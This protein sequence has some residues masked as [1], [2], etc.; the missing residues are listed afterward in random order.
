MSENHSE[1][2]KQKTPM[3]TEIREKE[4]EPLPTNSPFQGPLGSIVQ[5]FAIFVAISI[6][7]GRIYSLT[8]YEVLGIPTSE[9]RL[10]LTD[11]AVISSGTAIFGVAFTLISALF[12]WTLRI[13]E[14]TIMP[15]KAKF[16]MGLAF[17]S[18]SIVLIVIVVR[19]AL[20]ETAPD[21]IML[22]LQTLLTRE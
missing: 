3:E 22:T 15:K 2:E 9:V 19:D 17:F 20:Q 18:V 11:Y 6:L 1:P 5:S 4:Q 16:A 7:L 12:L 10:N 13:R 14:L 21:S 8:Y